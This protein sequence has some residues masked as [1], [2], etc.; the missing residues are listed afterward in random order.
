MFFMQVTWRAQNCLIETNKM[1]LISTPMFHL[2]KG[3]CGDI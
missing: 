1:D 3:V 2:S